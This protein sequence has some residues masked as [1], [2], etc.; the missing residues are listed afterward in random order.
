MAHWRTFMPRVSG[1]LS[2]AD[3]PE[4]QDKHVKIGEY[5]KGKLRRKD[6]QQESRLVVLLVDSQNKPAFLDGDGN[7]LWWPINSTNGEMIEKLTGSGDPA[8][9]V[10]RV[11]TLY[12]T[13]TRG[14]EGKTV[15]C[16]RVRSKLPPHDKGRN[17]TPPAKSAPPAASL[18]PINTANDVSQNYVEPYA[19][20]EE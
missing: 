15:A 10:G 3:V 18:P 13:E 5:R 19:G 17:A 2:A 6:N 4:G 8:D 11:I 14:A 9:W 16:V 1:M 20:P 12:Q 7:A